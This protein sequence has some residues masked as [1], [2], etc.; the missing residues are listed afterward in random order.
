MLVELQC[1]KFI[2]NGIVRPAIT[3]Q[4]GLNVVRGGGAGHNSIGK[5]TFL[6]VID[7]AFGGEDYADKT[8][9]KGLKDEVGPHTIK[10]AF[11]FDNIRYHFSRD[12]ENP[13]VVNY[14]KE[15]YVTVES[16]PLTEY[17]AFLKEKYRIG[18]EGISFRSVLSGYLRIYH[19]DNYNEEHP[20]KAFE[21]DSPTSGIDRLLKLFDLFEPIANMKKA[22]D[23]ADEKKKAY[24]KSQKY[25]I[26][27]KSLTK[28]QLKQNDQRLTEPREKLSS[29]TESRDK[30]LLQ[31][32]GLDPSLADKAY[33]LTGRLSSPQYQR[34]K[35]R[36]QLRELEC[37]MG[38]GNYK[39]VVSFDELSHFFKDADILRIEEIERFHSKIQSILGKQFD[40]AHAELQQRIALAEQDI[41]AVGNEIQQADLPKRAPKAFWEKCREIEMDIRRIEDENKN[42]A[43][44]E[45]LIAAAKS[46]KEALREKEKDQTQAVQTTTIEKMASLNDC[47][48][49]GTK[50]A[51][52]LEIVSPSNYEFYTPKDGGTGTAY[53]GLL[54][55]EISVLSL[56]RLPV[57]AHDSFL[58]KNI[59]DEALEKIM[60]LYSREVGK[61][62]FIALLTKWT[63]TRCGQKKLY[64]NQ[65]VLNS[66]AAGTN[67]SV[68]H[69]MKRNDFSFIVEG[70]TRSQGEG[71]NYGITQ[72]DKF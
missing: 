44:S 70:L 72:A 26:L 6:M 67:Y 62:V 66:H 61:Q 17:T 28:T 29:L 56:T 36:N 7:F 15:G 49:D 43:E 34:R 55:F 59:E 9:V 39:L 32:L 19:R 45:K 65:R 2:S 52:T 8:K 13:N 18:L 58:F 33:E 31:A 60:E 14:C 50:Q 11:E 5:S 54:L 48:Y 69:G 30:N 41:A 53:C 21:N 51:P 23:E 37:N 40:E 27:P 16:K 64:L 63:H 47:V 71:A 24:K 42:H 57:L 68:V 35:L 22:A 4:P 10:F 38:F 1:D 46:A 25:G 12:T 3:F 20:L